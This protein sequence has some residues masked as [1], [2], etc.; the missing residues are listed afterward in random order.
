MMGRPP[1]PTAAEL[2]EARWLSRFESSLRGSLRAVRRERRSQKI[3]QRLTTT[4][5]DTP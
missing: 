4:R 3:Y 5:E 1:E 2:D